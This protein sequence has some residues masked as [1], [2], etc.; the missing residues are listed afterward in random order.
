MKKP[1]L[2]KII[3]C[4][5]VIATLLAGTGV[6]AFAADS[7]PEWA[8][9]YIKEVIS[10]GVTNYYSPDGTRLAPVEAGGITWILCRTTSGER[11]WVGLDDP[12]GVLKDEDIFSIRWIR[13]DEFSGK[14]RNSF[15]ID[16]SQKDSDAEELAI[17]EFGIKDPDGTKLR[18]INGRLSLYVQPIDCF[19]DSVVR[20][21]YIGYAHDEVIDLRGERM[22]APDGENCR[23]IRIGLS[24]LD[25]ELPISDQI[26]FDWRS[27]LRASVF[28]KYQPIILCACASLLI[29]VVGGILIEKKKRS[30]SDR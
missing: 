20:A 6:S 18:D 19:I 9:S 8:E 3:L 28:S 13:S 24:Y 12:D 30:K 21:E 23:F 5:T 10:R 25:E 14:N 7:E 1:S 16:S 4:I 15:D 2:S 17:L 22:T 26:H 11:F 29:C 27:S